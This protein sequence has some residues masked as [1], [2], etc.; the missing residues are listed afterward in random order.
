MNKI[1]VSVIGYKTTMGLGNRIFRLL[2][3]ILIAKEYY[4]VNDEDIWIY[5]DDENKKHKV[6]N[7]NTGKKY[8]YECKYYPMEKLFNLPFKKIDKNELLKIL[9]DNKY[10]ILLDNDLRNKKP[11]INCDN[12]AGVVN[13]FPILPEEINEVK[14]FIS[15]ENDFNGTVAFCYDKLPD[16]Y[17]QKYRN[18]FKLININNKLLKDINNFKE[19]DRNT[20]GVHIRRGDFEHYNVKKMYR[21]TNTDDKY[22]KVIDSLK[23]FKN[24][25]L[26]SDDQELQELFKK[27][28]GD[29]L[30]YVKTESGVRDEMI[31]LKCIL[32]LSRCGH[33]VLS[34]LSSFS[35]F[36]WW[37][38][39]IKLPITYIK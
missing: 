4:K 33:L 23:N 28:Y 12:I 13:G 31:A 16:K 18:Y 5:Y 30:F 3:D 10:R 8:E 25:F 6:I 21:G 19:I 15:Y 35:E 38:S 9:N 2:G 20:I 34:H 11:Y 27:K 29:K 22:I 36:A 7:E 14:Q 24:I 32:L 37:M 26:S 39:D 1:I 17:W